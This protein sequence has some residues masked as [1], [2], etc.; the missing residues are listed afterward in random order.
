MQSYLQ[1][2]LKRGVRAQY[3]ELYPNWGE[4]PKPYITLKLWWNPNQDVD[5]LLEEWYV[6]CVGP[7][8]APA[9]AR[10]YAQWERFWT[11][12]ILNSPWFT[13]EGQYLAFNDPAY[14]AD[15]DPDVLAES[16]RLLEEVLAGCQTDAQRWRAGKLRQAFEY[17]E[18]TALAYQADDRLRQASVATESQALAVLM[19][20]KR[21]LG[22]GQ[23]RRHLAL[24]V[25]AKDPVLLHPLDID[26]MG[27]GGESWGDG[28]LWAVADWL[29]QGDNAV[30]RA[31]E[32]L[33]A[34]DSAPALRAQARLMLQLAAGKAVS[35]LA[36]G[37]FE[38]G[39]GEAATSW[40]Y[41]R[42]PDEPPAVPLGRMLRS[43]DVAHRGQYSLLYDS[44]LRGGPVQ[45][46]PSAGPGTYY[47]LCWVYTPAG[48]ENKGTMELTLGLLD[49]AAQNLPSPSTKL[50]PPA[51]RWTLL[52]VGGVVPAEVSGKKVA[53]FRPIPVLDGFQDG[54][55]VYVDDVELYWTE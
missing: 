41:W 3:A 20:S 42:K 52:A 7:E 6:R 8:A 31:V 30:R 22:L 1:Y 50:V 25:F 48:Q 44:M 5:D 19:D 34:D 38:E 37:S 9:L 32:A 39:D 29:T 40:G 54:G 27:L 33:A 21:A 47:A 12:D 17:Y 24:E 53:H 51:G 23:H 49:E 43:R 35:L 36:N 16:H 55:K 18:A 14:L 46:V 2:G 15:A 13:V 45:S 11:R 4:G 28:G 26:A 10:Y